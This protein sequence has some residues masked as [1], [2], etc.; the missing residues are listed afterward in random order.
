M[1]HS[2]VANKFVSA[3]EQNE[4]VRVSNRRICKSCSW[5]LEGDKDSKN[6][7]RKGSLLKS[8]DTV[9]SVLTEYESTIRN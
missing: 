9:F 1:R 2:I 4:N 3:N 5:Q 6:Q 7:S 8:R